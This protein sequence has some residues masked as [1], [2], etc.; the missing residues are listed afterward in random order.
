ME[1]KWWLI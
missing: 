1:E